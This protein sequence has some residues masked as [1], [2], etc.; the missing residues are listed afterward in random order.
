[1]ISS[2]SENADLALLLLS[3]TSTKELNTDYAIASGHLGV[4]KSQS[5]YPV[6]KT[7]KFLS[8]TLTLLEYTTFLPNSPYWSSYS[9]A[10]YLG[11]QAVESGDLTAAE[12]VDVVV[13]QLENELGDNVKIIP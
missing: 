13:A 5:D 6:Y 10:Y 9:E 1:M 7:A 3:K 8:D 12:A 11:I 4:L 2:Q